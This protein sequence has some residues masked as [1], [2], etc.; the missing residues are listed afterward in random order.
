MKR[1]LIGLLLMAGVAAHAE[2][3]SY[4]YWQVDDSVADFSYL[5]AKQQ[6]NGTF[7]FPKPKD[8][9]FFKVIGVRKFK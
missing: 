6:E 8:A 5:D 1:L 4:F 9:T 3:S 7:T 2:Y